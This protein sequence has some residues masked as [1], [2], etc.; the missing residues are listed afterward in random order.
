M[1]ASIGTAP[2]ED[3]VPPLERVRRADIALYRAKEN[4]KGQLISY[5]PDLD[6]NRLRLAELEAELREGL[7]AGEIAPVFQPLIS[8]ATGKMMGVESLARWR[9]K[10]GPVSP[11]VFIPLAERSGLI[12]ALGTL[13]L[14]SSVIAA[15]GW[16][17]VGLSVNVSP[18]QLCNP[19]FASNVISVLR[20][21]E[22]EPRRLTL[23][24]TEGVLMSNPDQVRR[25][26]DALR[27]VGVGFALDDFGCGY[28]SIGALRQFGFNR[29]KLDRSLVSAIEE[30]QGVGV[31]HAT[32]SLATA[33]GIPVTAEGVENPNQADVLTRAGCDLL[34]GYLLGRPAAAEEITKALIEKTICA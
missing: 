15:R 4:G 5:E 20:E 2:Q 25:T 19:D 7:A 28:A 31:L 1:G 27:A 3:G 23:E 21:L 29:M 6:R 34:Q 13:M 12:D 18:I 24:I 14:R 8:A 9:S 30:G 32:I 16:D 33:L 17:G 11:Q 22:F 26:M 10:K